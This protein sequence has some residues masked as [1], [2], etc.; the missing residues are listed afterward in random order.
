M[1]LKNKFDKVKTFMDTDSVLAE[2]EE[3]YC[4]AKDAYCLDTDGKIPDLVVFVETIED[5]QRLVKYANEHKIPVICRGAGT[6]MV[7]A[8]VC[9]QGGIVLNFSKMNKILELNPVN[10]TV[11]VQPGVI[12]GDLKKEAENLNLFYPPDPSN[13]RVSTVGGSIAQSSGGAMAFKYG[14]TKDYVLSLKVVT[15]DGSLMTL[16]AETIKDAS[17]YHLAQLMVGSEGT[18]A[19]V[20]EATLKLIPMPESRKVLSAY[21]R[22]TEDA[23][24]SVNKI[25][26]SNVF[27]SAIEFMDRN[28]ML[29]V[30]EFL[31]CGLCVDN[32]AMLLIELDGMQSSMS[33]QIAKVKNALSEASEIRFATTD[34]E[35]ELIWKARRSSFAA[36]A[37]LAPDVISDDIIVPRENLSKMAAI[38]NK[39]CSDYN[40]KLCLVG[41]AGD[42]NLHPQIA[43]DLDNEEEFQNCVKAKSEI[44]KAALDL[45]GAISSEHGIGIEKLS[46]LENTIDRRSMEYMK[47]IKQMFDPNNILN[48]GKIFKI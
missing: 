26:S 12:L 22:R 10:M 15:A 23:I 30:E 37:R 45:G 9:P 27:P 43:L 33:E 46:Y 13:F 35:A 5:V 2:L 39:I 6:N 18:L 14:T 4:Y 11:T 29:T 20:V 42:G 44:Y 1:L 21:F 48:P 28:S 19:I 36:A 47:M 7:G 32:E 3:R 8:C 41:H 38:C 17:G 31:S 34:E 24:T 25:I 16:G 40:L